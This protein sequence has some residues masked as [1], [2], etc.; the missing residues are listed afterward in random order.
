MKFKNSFEQKL[1]LA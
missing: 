1:F